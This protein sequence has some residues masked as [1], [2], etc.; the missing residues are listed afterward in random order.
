MV[1]WGKLG[2]RRVSG[3]RA[4]VG[5]VG[6]VVCLCCSGASVVTMKDYENLCVL[7]SIVISL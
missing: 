3:G 5:V 6:V 7:N 4:L 1:P 2:R